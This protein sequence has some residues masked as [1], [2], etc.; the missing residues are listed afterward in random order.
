MTGG[1]EVHDASSADIVAK[2]AV[3][4]D[5]LVHF[6]VMFG[7]GSPNMTGGSFPLQVAPDSEAPT[8]GPDPGSFSKGLKHRG[9]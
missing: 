7:A 2:G 5:E 4:R 1:V 9:R 8:R 3:E 6:G